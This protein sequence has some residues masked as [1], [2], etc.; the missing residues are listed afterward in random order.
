MTDAAAADRC[1]LLGQDRCLLPF[2]SDRFTVP[3]A[4]TDTGRRVAFNLES[5]PANTAGVHIDPTEWNRSDGFSAG[6][7]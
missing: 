6:A 5:M 3:D 2:P 1:E 4:S 7:L